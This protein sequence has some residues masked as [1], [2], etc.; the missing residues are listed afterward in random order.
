MKGNLLLFL[1]LL[2]PTHQKEH[3]ALVRVSVSSYLPIYKNPLWILLLIL[4][5][6]Q[7][8]NLEI[9]ITN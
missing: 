7:I 8:L 3:L 4:P 2:F 5:L 9:K 6:G 1:E